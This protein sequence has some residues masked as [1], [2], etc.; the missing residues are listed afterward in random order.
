M[1]N[2][3]DGKDII[4]KSDGAQIRSYCY[5]LDCASAILY[6]LLKAVKGKKD[7]DKVM[8]SVLVKFCMMSVPAY[9]IAIVFA[10][11]S[12]IPIYSFGMVVFWG[13]TASIIYNLLVTKN[14]IIKAEEK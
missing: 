3:A 13:I 2:A 7:N 14:L 11:N 9:I 5:M 6:V 4:M 12:F 1:Y 8:K 10:F